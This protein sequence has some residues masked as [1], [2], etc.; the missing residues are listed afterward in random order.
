MQK[1]EAAE[2]QYDDDT[3]KEET[4][5]DEAESKIKPLR[6]VSHKQLMEETYRLELSCVEFMTLLDFLKNTK[7]KDSCID[8]IYNKLCTIY[9][10]KLS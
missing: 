1:K 3:D 2:N 4:D 5:E 7:H 9:S 10:A 8:D 6:T